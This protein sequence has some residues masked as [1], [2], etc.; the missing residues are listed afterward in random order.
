M[1]KPAKGLILLAALL[2]AHVAQATDP[3][4]PT[5]GGAVVPTSA[6]PDAPS[7][8]PDG[9]RLFAA[10][11]AMCHKP[12]DLAERVQSAGD[13]KTA[14]ASLTTFLARHGPADAAADAAIIDWLLAGRTR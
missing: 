2:A 4:G 10:H 11:C 13:A 7:P 9:A 8:P 3:A 14:K 6:Q 1:A 5:E 12:A